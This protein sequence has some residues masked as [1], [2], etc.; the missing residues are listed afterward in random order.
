MRGSRCLVDSCSYVQKYGVY[1]FLIRRSTIENN[2]I[3]KKN[4][5]THNNNRKKPSLA[6]INSKSNWIFLVYRLISLNLIGSQYKEQIKI[7][8]TPTYS[9]PYIF[10]SLGVYL[11]QIAEMN[12]LLVNGEKQCSKKSQQ[13]LLHKKPKSIVLGKSLFGTELKPSSFRPPRF[14]FSLFS[15]TL[16]HM[17]NKVAYSNLCLPNFYHLTASI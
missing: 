15:S 3:K 2:G 6:S 4:T 7:S 1:Y 12:A 13:L 14:F 10:T 9:D 17:L 16:A 11:F 8:S 5:I